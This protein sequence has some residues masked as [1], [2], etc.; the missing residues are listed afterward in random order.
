MIGVTNPFLEIL[1]RHLNLLE[2]DF[3][4]VSQVL[5]TSQLLLSNITLDIYPAMTLVISTPSS[6]S[7]QDSRF[8]SSRTRINKLSSMFSFLKSLPNISTDSFNKIVVNKTRDKQCNA[9]L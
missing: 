4:V 3:T 7:I 2:S 5:H 1:S 9:V 8:N 6:L